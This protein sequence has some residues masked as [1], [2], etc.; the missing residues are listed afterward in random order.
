MITDIQV[1]FEFFPP[2]TEKMEE[3]LWQSMQG[4]LDTVTPADA[5]N[6]FQHAGYA[7]Y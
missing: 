7:T 6:C 3:T 4:V 1:S 5:R 2:A